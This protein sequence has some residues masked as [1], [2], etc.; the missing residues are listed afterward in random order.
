MLQRQPKGEFNVRFTPRGL[1]DARDSTDKFP[2]ACLQLK[3]LVFDQENP[4][5]VVARPGVREQA[6]FTAGGFSS[7]D[8]I[9]VQVTV[10]TVTYGLISSALNTGK[11]E[12]FA[13]DNLAEEFIAVTGVLNANS[14]STQL[15]TG[16][17]NPPTIASVGVYIIVTHPGFPGGS[18]KFGYFD[19]TDPA[20]PV[21]TA[22][23]TAT[24][25]LTGTPTAVANFNNRAYFAVANRVEYTDV[26]TLNRAAAAQS[27]TLG[28]ASVV[29]AL[30]GL[31]V[32]TT[33]SGVAQALVAFKAFQ[34][35]QI[36]GDP[37]G[38]TLAQNYLSLSIGSQAPRSIC[39]SPFGL[40][41]ASAGGPYMVDNLAI[42]RAIT[43]KLNESESDIQ[44]PF[45]NATE[46]SRIAG[47]YSQG[48]YR[49]C[50]DTIVRGV[51]AVNDYWFDEHR[52]RWTG[53]HSFPYACASPYANYMI[54]ASNENP[55]VLI[56]SQI[57]PDL[58]S[59]YTD[60]DLAYTPTLQSS[61]FPKEGHMTQKQVIE[62]TIELS[63]AGASQS[64]IIEAQD[65]QE[66]SLGIAAV[67]ITPTGSIWGTNVW[68]DGSRWASANTR[69]KVYNVPW[70]APLVFQK[71]S[72]LIGTTAAAAIAIGTFFARYQDLGYTNTE[73]VAPPG[74]AGTFYWTNNANV[75]VIWVTG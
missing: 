64:Y 16:P 28:D 30:S 23:D 27:L 1:V 40:Y 61:T 6:D 10:G 8:V 43:Y 46:P 54:L 26:L 48:I 38:S 75:G 14:P 34:V 41:F 21:W 29:T 39:Q 69:P 47:G 9:S 4:E 25:G 74:S 13:Y 5:L 51:Q 49:V 56:K 58:A 18:T 53:P 17:W 66:N 3:D 33:S 42:V 68:G 57:R 7:P 71:L 50:I 22:G 37:V 45:Q 59:Q 67:A 35:W 52:R 44:A 12:P 72:L 55:G 24:N 73:Q 2:G 60:L 63:A 36:T 11:D 15:T 20:A 62:S 70:G 19:I 65:D 32:Q 31:P